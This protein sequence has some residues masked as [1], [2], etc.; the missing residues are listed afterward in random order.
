MPAARAFA[1]IE[2]QFRANSR[3]TLGVELE[4]QLVDASTMMLR[5][6]VDSLLAELPAAL[7]DSVKRE[8]HSCCVEVSTDVCGNVEEVRRDLK[9]KL[10]RVASAAAHR[11][12]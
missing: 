3:P 2:S 12:L 9:A 5:C 1:M 10:R 7:A 4:L 6:G 11:G 8:F